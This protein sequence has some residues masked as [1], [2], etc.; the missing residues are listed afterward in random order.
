VLRS[1][2]RNK[3]QSAS[4]RA[5]LSASCDRAHNG[6]LLSLRFPLHCAIH[7]IEIDTQAAELLLSPHLEQQTK[8]CSRHR[9][10]LAFTQLK[11]GNH[12]IAVCVVGTDEKTLA[13]GPWGDI[14]FEGLP[15]WLGSRPDSAA[16]GPADRTGRDL[17]ERFGP[18]RWAGGAL[19][20]SRPRWPGPL[21]P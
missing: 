20:A 2:S 9:G 17:L 14:D 4:R 5:R 13:S 8:P 11:Q 16:R 3:F 6:W 19:V 1:Q 12:L 7:E 18:F 15:A 21:L 10:L